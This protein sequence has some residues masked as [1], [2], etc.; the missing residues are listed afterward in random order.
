M[1][2]LGFIF[3]ALLWAAAPAYAEDA[4]HV[5]IGGE[6]IVLPALD[7][8]VEMHGQNEQFDQL[9]R[10]FV[11]PENRLVA[12]YLTPEDAAAVQKDGQASDMSRYIMVQTTKA[13]LTFN[14]VEDFDVVREEII[15]G[16]GGQNPDTTR[17]VQKHLDDASGFINDKYHRRTQLQVGETRP[18]G[19][20]MNYDG[21]FGVAVLANL[22]VQSEEAGGSQ[23]LTIVTSV[24]ALNVKGRVLFVNTYS[25]YNG[26][27]DADF[28]RE[29]ARAYTRAVF[30]ANGQGE[31][32]E[33]ATP[34]PTLRGDHLGEEETGGSFIN[35]A[36]GGAFLAC[37]AILGFYMLPV[38]RRLRGG[39]D[40]SV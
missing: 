2:L 29:T 39:G 30:A 36:L 16:I 11:P 9:L 14:G 38:L 23:S 17:E 27:A 10:Q 32:S 6:D 35:I 20:F 7:G 21:A 8:M 37:V 31:P 25:H 24:T 15:K 5:T 3:I 22:G 4:K 13:D 33:S 12:V 19:A 1:R 28:V 18:L 40:R 26:D 34:V